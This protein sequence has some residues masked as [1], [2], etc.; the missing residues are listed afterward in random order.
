[1]NV[2]A[3]QSIM[4]RF[5][6]YPFAADKW[7]F[8]LPSVQPTVSIGT[9]PEVVPG[10]ASSIGLTTTLA[11]VS[12]S[13]VQINYLIRNVGLDRTVLAGAPQ[14]TGAGQWVIP[15]GQNTT[16]AL[17]PGAH[18]VTATVLGA[19]LGQPVTTTRAFIVI[20]SLVYF[21]RL[22]GTTE[23]EIDVL[24]DNLATA[25]SQ[26]TAANAN[27]ASLTTLLNVAIGLAIVGIV[28]A[29]V[30]VVMLARRGMAAKKPPAEEMPPMEKME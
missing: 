26:I 10:R 16:A 28:V 5:A 19:E 8:L 15:L 6:A 20:P 2:A 12:T 21:E 11:G 27:I 13:D 24:T 4:T 18:E 23:A 17:V 14:A 30:S 25:N 9:I 3:K 22:L 1:V 29:V 7:D